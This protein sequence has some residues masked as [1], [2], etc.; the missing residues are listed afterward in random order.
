ME[1]Q[2]IFH[3]LFTEQGL[4]MLSGVLNS[5]KAIEVNIGIMYAFVFIRQYSL[6]HNTSNVEPQM[7][8]CDYAVVVD[9][10]ED[11][12]NLMCLTTL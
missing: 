5:D 6:S 1:D 10:E 12:L 2:D 11:L 4:A 7:H 8:I 3:S 9:Q